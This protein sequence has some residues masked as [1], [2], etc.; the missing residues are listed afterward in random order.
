MPRESKA[1]RKARAVEIQRLLAEA[2]PDATCAL[3]WRNPFELL[4]ATILSAQ[5]TDETVNRVT[6]EL[7]RRY[8]T[9]KQFAGAVVEELEAIIKPSGFYHNKTKS[10]IG[11]GKLLAEEFGGEVP[12]S[13]AELIRLPGVSRKTASVVLGTAYGVA[14]GIVVDTHVSRLSLRMG[15]SAPQ[16]TVA[17]NTD[18]IEKDLMELLPQDT[19][20]M[21]GHCMVWHGRRVCAARKPLHDRCAVEGLCPRVGTD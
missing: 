20:I 14:E 12:R 10:L 11:A 15:L 18:K 8:Q 3:D 7:F 16:T 5:T 9:P 6:P 2:Y 1:N 21:F 17:V 4:A 19:W 13:M